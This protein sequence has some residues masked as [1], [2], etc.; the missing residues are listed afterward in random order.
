MRV[1]K[2]LR[3]REIES[4]LKKRREIQGERERGTDRKR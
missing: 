1:R 2:R 3:E 4:R